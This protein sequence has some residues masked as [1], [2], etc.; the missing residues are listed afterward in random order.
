MSII[1]ATTEEKAWAS[2][3]ATLGLLAE[4]YLKACEIIEPADLDA[5]I[6]RAAL[7]IRSKGRDVHITKLL[8]Q[9]GV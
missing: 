2:I 5:Y 8:E 3:D 7:P 4:V 1:P 6:E 9:E